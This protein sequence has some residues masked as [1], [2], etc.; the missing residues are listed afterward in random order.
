[1]A[2]DFDGPPMHAPG[3][4]RQYREHFHEGMVN[5]QGDIMPL[6]GEYLR[7]E[8]PTQT[9]IPRLTQGVSTSAAAPEE[10]IAGTTMG[11]KRPQVYLDGML[12]DSEDILPAKH[13]FIGMF[14]PPTPQSIC[15]HGP[16]CVCGMLLQ[17]EDEVFS[18][19][20]M[21]HADVPQYQS[22]SQREGVSNAH[23]EES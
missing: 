22:L 12:A 6:V 5:S 3:A 10:S 23:Q 17:Y 4:G 18:H 21:G 13:H 2:W 7:G 15:A 20:Q 9:I 11:D 8:S 19:W 16:R 14:R 1:M